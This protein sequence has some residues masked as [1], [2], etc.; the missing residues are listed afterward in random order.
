MQILTLQ[1]EG[2]N[3]VAFAPDNNTF[4]DPTLIK[5]TTAENKTRRIPDFLN[6]LYLIEN[7]DWTLLQQRGEVIKTY[8]FPD[9]LLSQIPIKEK[10]TNFY[11]LRAGVELIVLVNNQKFQQ[12]NLLISYLPNAKYNL[13]K[14]AMHDA[15]LEGLVSRTGSPRVNLDLMDTTRASLK[16]PYMS[17]FVFY[18][19]ITGAGTIGDFYISIYSPLFDVATGGKVSVSVYARFTDVDLEFPTAET[20]AVFSQMPLVTDSLNQLN[21]KPNREKLANAKNQIE[22]ILARIDDGSFSFQM[23]TDAGCFKQK[24][25]PKMATSNDNNLTHMLSTHS[26]N[27]LIP[28]NTGEASKNEMAFSTMLSIPTYY[29]FFTVSSEDLPGTNKWYKDVAPAIPPNINNILNGA[30]SADYIFGISALFKKW[31]G[32]IIYRF[33]AVKTRFHSLRLRVWFSAGSE[34]VAG[35]NRNT[36]YSKIVDLEVENSFTFEVPYIHPFNMLN[37]VKGDYSLGLIGVDIENQMVHPESVK[38]SIEIIVERFGAPDLQFAEPTSMK[39]FP[40]DPTPRPAAIPRPPPPTPEPVNPIDSVPDNGSLG[41]TIMPPRTRPRVIEDDT[42]EMHFQMASPSSADLKLRVV[43][44]HVEMAHDMFETQMYRG[45]LSGAWVLSTMPW[46]QFFPAVLLAEV[47]VLGTIDIAYKIYTN[48]L[49]KKDLTVEGIEP[50]PGPIFTETLGLVV[51]Q[52]F[53]TA[54]PYIG[55]QKI[56]INAFSYPSDPFP[57]FMTITGNVMEGELCVSD[58]TGVTF[59]VYYQGTEIPTMTIVPS[60]QGLNGQMNIIYTTVLN[61]SLHYQMGMD[62]EQDMERVGIADN[63]LVNPLICNTISKYCIGN[64]MDNVHQMIGRS[65]LFQTI[66]AE[67]T[68]VFHLFPHAI[69]V[70]DRGPPPLNPIQKLAGHD[71]LSYFAAFFTFA[72]GTVNFRLQTTGGPYRVAIDPSN[73]IDQIENQVFDSLVTQGSTLNTNDRIFSS[74]LMQQSINTA[75]EGFGEFAVPFYSS[76][77]CYSINPQNTI[78]IAKSVEDFTHPDTQT[79][80]IP[81]AQLTELILF[82]NAAPDF[83]MSYLSGPPLLHS[84]LVPN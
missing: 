55:Q 13:A 80:I 75:V 28:V 40:F 56:I 46:Y 22:N 8:R 25:L 67:T 68:G 15:N 38:D 49:Y 18:N 26:Q 20:P 62:A 19:L 76:T 47:A 37:V 42:D 74:N 59:E 5:E 21:H 63:K 9:T 73:D 17:P 11:G 84:I 51:G 23:N 34:N 30:L 33:R 1:D 57:L 45:L 24:A 82:R 65:T 12:G 81:G 70:L 14:A 44:P 39:Y 32:G 48:L 72:R 83:E 29:D 58:Y 50:N 27:S 35:L 66:P 16:V 6:R 36:V 7:F 2:S 43:K 69:G 71:N 77:F 41:G 54:S 53:V 64:A 61:P 78:T 3:D 79:L 52:T 10:I 4:T 60:G 31:K